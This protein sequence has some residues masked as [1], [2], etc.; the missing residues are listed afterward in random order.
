[1]WVRHP[2]GIYLLEGEANCSWVKENLIEVYV[3]KKYTKRIESSRVEVELDVIG[4]SAR[5]L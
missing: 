1:M 2:S 3:L 5:L 4:R